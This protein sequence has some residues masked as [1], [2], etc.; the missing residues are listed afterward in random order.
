MIS[1]FSFWMLKKNIYHNDPCA[2]LSLAMWPNTQPPS[3]LPE[4]AIQLVPVLLLVS[5]FLC[6]C[7]A[8][9]FRGILLN[10]AAAFIWKVGGVLRRV[11]G[12]CI[13]ELVYGDSFSIE[14]NSEAGGCSYPW[15]L[16]FGS[17]VWSKIL[18]IGSRF[19][20]GIACCCILDGAES[21]FS[22]VQSSGAILCIC[23]VIALML[24]AFWSSP[25]VSVRNL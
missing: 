11:A 15:I 5:G 4:I 14:P 10:I 1:T 7:I 24:Y 9:G 21:V 12:L 19:L 20:S 16:C 13:R 8:A 18:R 2:I 3:F 6:C 17:N 23:I 25:I 22:L